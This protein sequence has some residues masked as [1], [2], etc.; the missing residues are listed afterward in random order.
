MLTLA[1]SRQLVGSCLT[2][3][4]CEQ[5]VGQQKPAS[6]LKLSHLSQVSHLFSI[7]GEKY[8]NGG[9]RTVLEQRGGLI[10]DHLV[11]LGQVRQMQQWRAFLLRQQ[12]GHRRDRRD[13]KQPRQ[14]QAGV[15]RRC[16]ITPSHAGAV[17]AVTTTVV[18]PAGAHPAHGDVGHGG[19][20]RHA[21]G[22]GGLAS[23]RHRNDHDDDGQPPTP[24]TNHP[25]KP[26]RWGAPRVLSRCNPNRRTITDG[27]QQWHPGRLG[28]IRRAACS[29]PRSK[30]M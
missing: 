2:C 21:H 17:A 13:S 29:R 14:R 9:E 28:A 4:R 30:A 22:D 16:T 11:S 27:E 24:S 3:P 12:V 15:D 23:R 1:S 20:H 7:K 26:H 6:L 19:R 10:D 8:K 25:G 5:Q 18:S